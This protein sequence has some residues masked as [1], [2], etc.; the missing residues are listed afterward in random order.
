MPREQYSE[1]AMRG[2]KGRRSPSNSGSTPLVATS[3]STRPHRYSRSGLLNSGAP[4]VSFPP[5]LPPSLLAPLPR[6]FLAE[7]PLL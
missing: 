4:V 2:R 1:T 5:S 6:F 3:T 7:L